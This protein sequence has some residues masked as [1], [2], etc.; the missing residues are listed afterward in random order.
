MPDS[1][2]MSMMVSWVRND[3]PKQSGNGQE[4]PQ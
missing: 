3:Q 2:V 1:H 4:E